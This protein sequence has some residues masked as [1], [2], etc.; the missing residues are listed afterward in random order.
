MTRYGFHVD[1]SSC[2]GCKACQIA[3]KDKNQLPVDILWRRIVD[4][5]GGEWTRLGNI[6]IDNTF[7]Y[8][9]SVACMHCERPICMEVCPTRAITQRDD[10]I[11]LID[12]D[13]CIGCR[14]C[15]WACPYGAP[16]FD[17][18]TKR[19]GKCNLCYDNLD[20]GLPPAC[21]SACQLRVIHF[22]DIEEL[23]AEY[24]DLDNAFPLPSA[25]L[26]GPAVTLTPHHDTVLD[27]NMAADIGNQ[28][29]I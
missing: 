14:Y 4:V 9:V 11:V 12:E 23:R 10:G 26:T 3:C 18:T 22:G 8:F 16:Q 29:E 6:W 19:M 24:G 2:V 5:S 15:E 1:L 7:N 17:P 21:V 13:V 27:D 28:E 25:D 20:M